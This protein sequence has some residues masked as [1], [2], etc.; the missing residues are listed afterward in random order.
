MNKFDYFFK[1]AIIV[2][3]IAFLVLFYNFTKHKYIKVMII[4]DAGYNFEI[5]MDNM[6]QDEEYAS[7]HGK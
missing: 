7:K 4:P 5:K 6:R 1:T 2:I 3:C